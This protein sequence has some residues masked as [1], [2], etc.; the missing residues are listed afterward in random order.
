[1]DPLRLLPCVSLNFYIRCNDCE[2]EETCNLRPIMMRVRDANLA[3]YEATTLLMLT[4]I[5]AQLTQYGTGLSAPAAEAI[6]L[7]MNT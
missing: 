4:E 7:V 3:V 6:R 5:E 1:M 2:D